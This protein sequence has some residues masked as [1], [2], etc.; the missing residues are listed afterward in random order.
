MAA[1]EPAAADPCNGQDDDCDGVTDE[2]TPGLGAP[3]DGIELGLCQGAQIGWTSPAVW[4]S[5]IAAVLLIGGLVWR[6][7]RVPS[8]MLDLRL[9]GDRLF[10]TGNLLLLAMTGAMFSVLFL[11]PL[12]LQTLRGVSPMFAGLTMRKKPSG[13]GACL[14][15]SIVIVLVKR[16]MS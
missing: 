4:L 11:I 2:D 13:I 15:A 8:P 12:Y 5:L 9:L 14:G 6:E 3:C 10:G 7:L 16:V 1:G